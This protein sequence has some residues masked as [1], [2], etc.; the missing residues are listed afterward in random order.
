MF[1]VLHTPPNSC[2]C[3][4]DNAITQSYQA[5]IPIAANIFVLQMP[6]EVRRLLAFFSFFY[7]LLT[8][9]VQAYLTGFTG[10]AGCAVVTQEAAVLSTDGRYFNQAEHQLDSNWKLLKLGMPD[11]PTWQEW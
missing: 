7:L 3:I 4:T 11:V 10:S 8:T 9:F 2:F 6:E 5:R 1:T